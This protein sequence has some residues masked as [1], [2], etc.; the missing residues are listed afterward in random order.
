MSVNLETSKG[1]SNWLSENAEEVVTSPDY[2][3]SSCPIAKWIGSQGYAAYVS[4]SG[5]VCVKR[6]ATH[7]DRYYSIPWVRDFV[8]AFDNRRQEEEEITGQVC[9]D[10][11]KG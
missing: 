1:F 4:A 5:Y 8:Y 10:I 2:S 3:A 7:V 11:L 6:Y 9:L